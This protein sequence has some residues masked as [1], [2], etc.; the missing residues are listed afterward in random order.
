MPAK[1]PR[2]CTFRSE[3]AVTRSTIAHVPGTPLA[4]AVLGRGVVDPAQ[5]LL[6][7]DDEAVLR[8]RAAFETM[9]VYAGVPFRVDLHLRRL[10]E[11]ARVLELPPPALSALERLVAAALGPP[12]EPD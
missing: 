6:R 10:G 5:P 8:G 2:A 12:E 7:A 11:S 9:R 1:S 3:A 4:L